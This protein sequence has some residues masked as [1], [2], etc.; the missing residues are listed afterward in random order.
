M[1]RAFI[2]LALIGLVSTQATA[3]IWRVNNIYGSNA[4]FTTGQAAIDS[5]ASGD[6]IY[7]EASQDSY[8]SI[9]LWKKLVIIGTGYFLDQNTGLQDNTTSAKV[10]GVKFGKEVG[11]GDLIAYSSSAGSQIIGMQTSGITIHVPNI[12]IKRCY[13]NSI[14]HRESDANSYLTNLPYTANASNTII[15]QCFISTS[16]HI[17]YFDNVIISNSIIGGGSTIYNSNSSSGVIITNN[18]FFSTSVG[19]PVNLFNATLSNNI[20]LDTDIL[21]LNNSSFNNNIAQNSILPAGNGNINGAAINTII[22]NIGTDDGKYRLAETSVAIDAGFGGVDCGA[23]GGNNPYV[24][25]GIPPV[26]T[27]YKLTTG[28]MN[29]DSIPVTISVKSNN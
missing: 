16:I 3:K 21:T 29:T 13:V 20:F 23:F 4:D 22:L 14:D 12:L 7:F 1:K 2:F 18:T 11:D 5:A 27:I 15:T 17:N 10:D 19:S 8:G 24:L 6:T 26:P 25:S 9:H 28:V